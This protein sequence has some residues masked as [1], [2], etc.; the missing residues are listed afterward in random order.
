MP[1]ID[2]TELLLD[3]DF[4]EQ[5]TVYRRLQNIDNYGRPSITPVLVTPAPYGVVEPQDDM[6]LQRG[7]DQQNL[8]QLLEVHTIFRL[9]SAGKA[10]GV[11]YQPDVIVWNGTSFLVNKIINWSRYG[12]GFV[13]A[14][15]SS[16][17][18]IDGVP[19]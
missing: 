14:Q 11:E 4:C 7:E 18:A 12:V 19:L 10:S 17:D 1:S 15:C 6:P 3:L 8:P 13:R 2:V 16:T 9:R 5:L